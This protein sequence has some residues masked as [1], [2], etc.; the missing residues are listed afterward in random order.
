M[1][2][3]RHLGHGFSGL[4]LTL[5]MLGLVLVIV[6][7]PYSFTDR[8]MTLYFCYYMWMTLSLLLH[9]MVYYCFFTYGVLYD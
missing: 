4:R 2:L 9:L 7:P 5:L 8:V 1:F 6:T 3:S